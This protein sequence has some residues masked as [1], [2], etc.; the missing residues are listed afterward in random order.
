MNDRASGP[1]SSQADFLLLGALG[2]VFVLIEILVIRRYGWFRDEL[3]YLACASHLAW[4]YVDHPPLSIAVLALVRAALGDSLPAIR[5]VP[6]LLGGATVVLAGSLAR[7]LGGRRFAQALTA[8]AVM[9]VPTYLALSHFYSMNAFELLFW[10]LGALLLVRA[11]KAGTPRSWLALGLALGLGLQNKISILWLGGGIA[12]GL[13]LTPHRRVLLTPWPWIAGAIAGLVFLPYVLWQIPNGWPTLEFMHNATS[14]KMATVSPVT[15]IADQLLTMNPG[16]AP[17]WIAGLVFCLFGREGRR[18]RILGIIYLSVLLLLMLGGRSRASYL[19]PAYPMLFAAGAIALESA[20]ARRRWRWMKPASFPVL[21]ASGLVV[22]PMAVPL[23]P[24]ETFIRYQASLGMAPRT[25]EN[26][27]VGP[28]PQHYADMFGWEELAA[29][30][31]RVYE[32]L[33]AE[34]RSRCAIFAENYG[35]AGAI[36]LFGRRYGLP[37]ALS[38]HNSYWL[39]GPGPYTGECVIAVGGGEEDEREN[40]RE[41]TL[42]ATHQ[43]RYCMPYENDLPIWI[44]RG[45][46]TPLP[47]LWP[48]LRMYI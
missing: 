34:E 48:A 22:A 3:Y 18:W 20:V 30:V 17:L 1:R 23:L 42:G 47:A 24:V 31:A 13:L 14:R 5:I 8:V 21:V 44:G 19:S 25:E 16:T 40:F 12:L 39:W 32:S 35:E 15:F 36:D 43:C 27:S 6:A 10:T 4:G 37:K 46:R 41:V 29:T 38:G 26:V 7:E 9:S 45:L 2:L 11:L 28:L 33:P